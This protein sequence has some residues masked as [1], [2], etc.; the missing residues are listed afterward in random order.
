MLA[1]LKE[2]ED[3][4]VLRSGLTVYDAAGALLPFDA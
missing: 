1:E 2:R 3:V 4:E